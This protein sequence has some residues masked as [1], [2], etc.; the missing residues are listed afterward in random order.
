M[1]SRV[2]VE[3]TIP[4]ASKWRLPILT[5]HDIGVAFVVGIAPTLFQPVGSGSH[6]YSATPTHRAVGSWGWRSYRLSW[7]FPFG[8]AL[9]SPFV[10]LLYHRSFDLSRV[11]FYFF[12]EVMGRLVPPSQ[13]F[14]R[15]RTALP[16]FPSRLPCLSLLLLYPYCITTWEI[17]Q[18]VSENFFPTF[19]KHWTAARTSDVITPSRG[20][21]PNLPLTPIV[22]H[23]HP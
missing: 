4:P 19:W 20:W 6:L 2:G 8:T 18:G 21:R 5:Y 1:V 3:P 15:S 12:L 11:F 22:Y 17:C 13:E 7:V 14:G 23:I 16:P 9:P 10:L